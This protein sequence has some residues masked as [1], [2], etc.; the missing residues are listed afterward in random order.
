MSDASNA[1]HDDPPIPAAGAGQS[2]RAS[3]LARHRWLTYLLPLIVFSALTALEPTPLP[4]QPDEAVQAAA[5]EPHLLGLRYEHYPLVYTVKIALVIASMALVWPGYREFPFRLSPLAV[6]VG[7]V[8]VVVWIGLCRLQLEQRILPAIGLGGLTDLGQRSAFNPLVEM[9]DHRLLAAAFLFVRFVGLAAVVP[10][11]EE[12]FLR[13]FLMR[14]V[15][16]AEWWKIP[17]GQVDKLAL[18]VGTL[19]PMLMHPGE[20]VAAGVW[21][22]LVTWLMVRTRNIWDCVVA[23]AVTNLLLGLF[24]VVFDQW[25]LM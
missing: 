14:F 3:L 21:F 22:S 20:L 1:A 17:F 11:I 10:I 24:V 4:E 12:F 5:P 25:H 13:G 2:W 7:V 18:A 16:G 15:M 8:G 23:H 9:A 6:V 19:V